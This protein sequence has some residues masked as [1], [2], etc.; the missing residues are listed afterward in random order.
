MDGDYVSGNDLV[1]DTV[2]SPAQGENTC[3]GKNPNIP[4][5]DCVFN[6]MINVGPQAGANITKG[7]KGDLEVD[8]EPITDPYWKAGL[9]P[10]NVHWHLGAEHYSVGQFDENG[11]GS[12]EIDWTIDG[13][14]GDDLGSFQCHHYDENDVKFT[15]PYD[16]KHCIGVEVG[17][18]YEVSFLHSQDVLFHVFL[19]I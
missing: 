11:K 15:R 13:G 16:W 4:N 14:G 18:T 17:Q 19:S 2:N 8:Y 7:Y 5:R 12:R 10:V 1:P 9:C 3:A 6:A